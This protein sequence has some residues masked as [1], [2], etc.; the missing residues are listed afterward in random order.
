MSH[1][2][3]R[4][5]RILN[6][7][8]MDDYVKVMENQ[9]R[10]YTHELPAED[11]EKLEFTK[12]NLH[13]TGRILRTYKVSEDLAELVKAIDDSQLWLVITEPW[14]GDSAQCL[15]YIATMADLN[16]NIKLRMVLRDENLDIIDAF[17]TEGKRSIPVLVVFDSQDEVLFTWGPRPAPAQTVFLEAKAEG[18]EKPGILERLHLFYGRDRGKSIEAEFKQILG[19]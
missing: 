2:L 16:P 15:P 4:D 19:G 11:A 6:G 10:L 18:L 5:S 3:A 14:C 9:A 12:L 17:L 13:R 7:L 8:S 1:P